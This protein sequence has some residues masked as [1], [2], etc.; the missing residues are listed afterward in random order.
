MLAIE[1]TFLT[2]EYSA[3]TPG[4][5][6]EWPPHPARLIYALA[7][8]WF[9]GGC[10][11][12]E[13][14]ALEWL[15]G[16]PPPS[17]VAHRSAPQETYDAWVPM[18]SVPNWDKKGGKR[19]T[20]PKAE[21]RRSSRFVGDQPVTFVWDDDAPDRHIDA[22]QALCER[23]T[24]LGSSDSLASFSLG[25]RQ[26]LT[27]A[28]WRPAST[29]T[30]LRVSMPGVLDTL[31]AAE[32]VMPGRVLPC[33]WRAYRWSVARQPGRMI[34]VGL[35]RGSWPIERTHELAEQLRRALIQVAD[36]GGI[37]LRPILHGHDAD[38][39][40][41]ARPHLHFCPL[42]HVGFRHATGALVGVSLVLPADAHADDR[43]YVERLVAAWFACGA[44]LRLNGG[45]ELCFGPADG[46]RG[47]REGRWC[48]PASVWRTVTPME[49]PRHVVKRSGWNRRT[50][51]RAAEAVS[52]ACQH[53]GLPAPEEVEVSRT[54]FA[55]GSPHVGA[56]RARVSRPLLHARLAFRDPVE[57]PVV[58]G[59]SK[60]VGLGLMEPVTP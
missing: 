38:G 14:R 23:T 44:S 27:G 47:L 30:P 9:D 17:I 60:H 46:R 4:M 57:G 58:L 28:A 18:N 15:E 10:A 50:W 20:L 34:T 45:R 6:S 49:L 24:R 37:P 54:P 43:G 5:G 2:G 22:L 31:R 51:E 36:E 12:R 33:D 19:P 40:P 48:R 7:A 29:G 21:A 53:A 59:A 26:A 35:V 25:E 41:L 52:L 11:D 8:S 3:W 32:I 55:V 13:L 16:Q 39:S 42:P 1:V 56:L